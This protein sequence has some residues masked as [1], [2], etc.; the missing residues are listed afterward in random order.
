[1]IT[2]PAADFLSSVDGASLSQY[3]DYWDRLAPTDDRETFQ[4]WLFAYASV[5]TTWESNVALFNAIKGC[6]WLG[7]KE[8]LRQR[9][10]E[11]RAGLHNKRADYIMDF[12]DKFWNN[13]AAF[14][15]TSDMP[16]LDFR[17]R[18]D[19]SIKGLG[20][21]KIAFA[22]EMIYP[23]SVQLVCIDTHILN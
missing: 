4:R 10:I 21:A 6:E 11:S 3:V 9:I 2:T 5:H 20:R 7:S 1:M 22:Y 17:R 8:G 23:T 12:S 18:I 16:W 19:K 14:K 13:P 15:Y